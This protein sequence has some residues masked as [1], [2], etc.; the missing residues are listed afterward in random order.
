MKKAVS[1]LFLLLF[2]FLFFPGDASAAPRIFLHE[3]EKEL[4]ASPEVLASAASLAGSRA[5]EERQKA[6]GGLRYFGELSFGGM[7]E[8]ESRSDA[9]RIEGYSKV[10][11]R[12]GISVPLFGT[13]RKERIQELEAR[14]ASLEEE[15]RFLTVR[16]ANLTALRKAYTLLWTI[17][18][19][20]EFLQRFLD[21]EQQIM[22]LLGKRTK[23]GVLLERD[24]LEMESWFALVRREMAS[25]ALLKE[26]CLALVRK[27]TG[28]EDLSDLRAEYPA[29]PGI[30]YTDDTPL[31]AAGEENAELQLLE[32]TAAAQRE[33]ARHLPKAQYDSF[34]RAGYGYSREFPGRNGTEAFI[35]I[36]VEI[37][38]GEGRAAAAAARAAAAAVK[39]AG[40]EMALRRLSIAG[41][42]REG[43]ARF[44]SAHAQR[45]FAMA[46]LRS[47]AEAVR[48]DR[49]RYGLL[50]GD[51][52]EQ[53]FR[54]LFIYLSSALSLLD[55]E[56]AMLQAHCELLGMIPGETDTG[57]GREISSS[58]S[59]APE[60]ALLLAPS[61]I[62][63]APETDRVEKETAV[64]RPGMAFYLWAGDALL[65]P[66]KGRTFF[67]EAREEG[68]STVLV[69]FTSRGIERLRSPEGKAL[70]EKALESARGAGIRAELLLGDPSWILPA[71]RKELT[72][73]VR[74]LDHFSFSGIHLDLEPD[75]L[76]GSEKKRGGL[77]SSLID[78]VREVKAVSR[79]PVSLSVHPRYLEGSLGAMAAKGLGEAGVEEITV[80]I[81]STNVQNAAGRMNAI[82]SSWPGLRFRLAVSVERELPA[83]ESFFRNG[84][85]RFLQAL[86]SLQRELSSPAF[87]GVVIQSWENYK[88]MSQ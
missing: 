49:L 45:D 44:E 25:D 59:G 11:L 63:F 2:L 71:H 78:T 41:G 42:I 70:L 57:E 13:W 69:S 56:G 39:K 28:R 48:A 67:S 4:T 30:R 80:M 79:L 86:D 38:S 62:A 21:L 19:K 61:W 9:S 12:A 47:S 40:H 85:K 88:E 68:A 72:D 73:L 50:P 14:I 23:E 6:A 36:A 29:L 5:L 8:P 46:N 60:R 55:S 35:S 75:Q 54:S 10:S 1:F 74:E 27:A 66:G 37:P 7:N 24:R 58:I 84:K 77:L 22:P 34:L 43:F 15:L 82:L 18:E 20:K 65:F 31:R 17:Q 83:T 87:A 16:K 81:Y 64:S 26:E 3:L 51:M 53:L 32:R 76:P 52:L 33:I